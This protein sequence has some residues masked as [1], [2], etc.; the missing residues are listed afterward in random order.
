MYIHWDKQFETGQTLIDTEH[1]LLMMLFRKLDIA[2][3][4]NQPEAILSRIVLEVVKFADFHF[5][6]EENVMIET[7]YPG[8]ETHRAQH[9]ELMAELNEKVGRLAS[10]R[11]FPDDLLDFLL[12]WL[13]DHIAHHDQLVAQ[14]VRTSR[15]RPVAEMIYDEYLLSP[16]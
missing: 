10:H 2:I 16:D 12:A 8:L 3:K 7:A 9:A 14:H 11:E 5:I 15:S 4:T 13:K 1:R 6:S